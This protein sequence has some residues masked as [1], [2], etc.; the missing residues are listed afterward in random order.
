MSNEEKLVEYLKRV[1]A[2]LQKSRQRL[3][4]L[5]SGAVE[6]VAIV[7]A[8]CRF[9][10]GVESPDDLWELVSDG[11]DAISGWPADRGWDQ[12]LYD[13]EP[14]KAGRSY[15][16][17]GGFLDG[18]ALFD[19]EFFGISPREALSMDPQ[20]RVLLETAWE[21]VEQAGLDVHALRGSRTGVFVGVV[22]ESYLGLNAPEEFEGYLMTSKLSSVAS[23]RIAYALGLEGPAV[24]L[25][26]ACSSSLVAL[27]LAVQSVRSGESALALAGGATVNG[28]PGGFVD[29]SRQRGLAADG[30]IKSFS[31]GADGTAWAEGVGLVLLERLSDAR[32]NGHRVLA[33]IRGSA[34]NQDGAS[35]GLTAP[36]GPAQERVIRQALANAGLHTSDVDAVEAHGTG[37]PLGDPIEAQALIATYGQNRPADRPLYLGSLKSNI[38]HTV[39]AA[40]IGGVIKMVQAMRHGTLPRTLHVSEPTPHVDWNAGAVELLTDERPWPE[41]DRPRRAAVSAFGVSGTN[42]HVVLEQAPAPAPAPV[43]VS[44]EQPSGE[45]GEARGA[46]PWVLSAK[47]PEGLSAQARRLLDHL[48]RRPELS[49]ADVALS[50]LTT[51]TALDHRAAVVG[52]TRDELLE[53]LEALARDETTPA[54]L[55]PERTPRGGTA[56]LFTGQGSQRPGTGRELYAAEPVFARALDEAAVHLDPHLEHPLL[57][58]MFADGDSPLAAL[59]HRTEYTQPALFALGTALYRLAEHRGLSADHFLGHSIGEITAAHLAGVLD[60]PDACT[61]VAH[62]ARL[63][64]SAPDHGAMAALQVS[65]EEALALLAGLDPATVT[66]ATVNGPRSTVISG[67]ADVVESVAERLRAEG[68]RAKRLP[69]SHAF[70][71]PHMD[72]IL[73]EFRAVAEGLTYHPPRIPVVSNLTGRPAEGTDL[74]TADYWVRQ[75]RG[76]VRFHDGLRHLA[77]QGVTEYLESGPDGTLTT[78]A[79]HGLDQRPATLLPLLRPKRPETVTA[80]A[81]LTQLSLRGAGIDL[82][83]LLPGASAVPLPTY[84]FQHRRYWLDA[85]HTATDPAAWG[86][87]PTE[88]P[89]LGASVPVADP[90]TRLF[91]GRAVPEQ[92]PWL[93]RY[94][95]RDSPLLPASALIE[96]AIRAGDELGCTRLDEL[97][98]TP[99]P[100]TPGTALQLQT[101]VTP[102]DRPHR[103]RITVHARPRTPRPEAAPWR[104]CAEGVVSFSGPDEPFELTPWPP[105]DADEIDLAAGRE[106]LTDAGLSYGP[107][108][109]GVSA[110]W[111]RGDE[112]FAEVRGDE[113]TGSAA[114]GFGLDPA[115][116][117]TALSA[118]LLAGDPFLPDGGTAPVVGRCEDVRLHATGATALRVRLTRTGENTVRVLLAD[119]SGRPVAS[120]GSLEFRVPGEGEIGDGAEPGG[121]LF[122]VEQRP[123]SLT[124]PRGPLRW[125]V[126]GAEGVE[127]APPGAEP[128]ATVASVREAV[129]AGRSLD[130]VA[131]PWTPGTEV[132]AVAAHR[133][134]LRALELLKEWLAEDALDGTRLV[135]LTQGGSAGSAGS[136]RSGRSGGEAPDLGAATVHGLVRSAQAE[137]PRRITLIDTDGRAESRAALGAALLSGEPELRLRAGEASVPRLTRA[138]ADPGAD[139]DP[140]TVWDP[141]GTVLITGGTGALGALFAEHLITRHGV[142]HL[143]LTSRKGPDA[144]GARELHDRLTGLGAT[145]AVTACDTTDRG[146]LAR[147]LGDI[148]ADRPLTGVIHAAGVTDDTLIGTLT[149][150][151]LRPVLAAKADGAWHLHQLTRDLPLTAFV[152]FSSAAATL[153]GPAQGN[154]AAANAFLDALAHHRRRQGLAAASLAWG[155]WDQPTGLSKHLDRADFQRI[156]RT[157]LRPVEERTGP[158]L[159]DRA[160]ATGGAA[161]VVTPIDTDALRENAARGPLVLT[162]LVGTPARPAAD[163]EAGGAGGSLA[164]RLAG[165]DEGGQ[166]E[167]V[168]ALVR[169]ETAV[170]LGHRD[171]GGGTVAADQPF[172]SVGFDSLT[173]VELRNRLSGAAGTRLPATLVFDHPTPAALAGYLREVLV[174]GAPVAAPGLFVDFAAEVRLGDDVRPAAEVT[175]AVTDPSAVLLTGATGFLGAFLLRDLMTTTRAAVHCL[176]R[177]TSADQ[178]L[179]RIRSNLEWYGIWDEIDPARLRIVLGDLERPRLGL[180]EESFDALSRS[181]DAVY[182]AGATVHW[183]RP[184][185]EL[186]AANVGGTEEILR[187]AAR[188]RTVPVHHVSSVGVFPG[189]VV[190]GEPVRTD[191]PTGPPESLPTGYVQ[192][193]WVAERLIDLARER[194]LPVS[195]YRVD[196]ISGDQRGGACQTQDFVWLSLKGLLEAGSVPE[197]LAG[198]VHAVP[199]DHVSGAILALSLRPEATGRTFHISNRDSLEFPAFL[200]HLRSAGYSLP[201]RP[202]EEWRREVEANPENPINPLMAA[203]EAMASDSSRFYPEF[204]VTDTEDLLKGSGPVCPAMDGKLFAKY[205]DFF[206]RVGYF[207]PAGEAA[208]RT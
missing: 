97:T 28:D 106:R 89:L 3:E 124:A 14:G 65:E 134:A 102:G 132:G 51:R 103:R 67:D 199:V 109:R 160:L 162:G 139:A 57:Q 62:R 186:R 92:H 185:G 61:L 11:R 146:Q 157:G 194:G 31:A 167:A 149:P 5:E 164:E 193:K 26:T 4:E 36:N 17:E 192:S 169:S 55:R 18:A 138:L 45:A 6:P 163:N 143:V 82:T 80:V 75:L 197:G 81:A 207:P 20:Q 126:L 70:H 13:P 129:A 90:D 118:A 48:R 15:T 96:T 100:L 156:A 127:Q 116:L 71:S 79:E 144:P 21:T 203:F 101:A 170:V 10:G 172:R 188:H 41:T 66:V 166:Y 56:V 208:P 47:T 147:L 165:L 121:S 142:T 22:E 114:R 196:V 168:L 1:T 64:Q 123:L 110:L 161:L 173:S 195:V 205:V 53:A 136:G 159:M 24:S 42:A 60:L 204:D 148:P 153:G 183:L 189:P 175:E 37:T 176:V 201:E 32:R 46:V 33:V 27:H 180:T 190:E 94:T 131:V 141:S 177:G 68:H 135:L 98:L 137:A 74:R 77:E 25:D 39:A 200:A 12:G 49:P 38:G 113:E 182:H 128:F 35:N 122:A 112:I 111:R 125:G 16:R 187:L 7:G 184:Y 158:A 87:T 86:L 54:V 63:M 44:T 150:E 145:V 174:S 95:H 120:V 2:D 85:D 58:V 119:R 140:G 171:T 9:P 104:L 178:A 105:A 69:V 99:L 29:F 107:G 23:G 155:L 154:Y 59:L 93:T 43:P 76:A 73:E 133:D 198:S 115:L 206:V 8:A 181:A 78:L 130:A 88:H 91:A 19:A 30:R 152:L 191:D 179:G 202:W 84:A 50:L 83:A 52:S 108:L 40:G 151:R 72:G 117:E 34:V